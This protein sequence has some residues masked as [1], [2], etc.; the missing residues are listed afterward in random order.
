M[1]LSQTE[2]WYLNECIKGETLLCQ[3]LAFYANQVQ[4][5]QLRGLIGNLQMTCQRHVDMLAGHIR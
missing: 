4:D 5:P 1:P 2:T 3:K